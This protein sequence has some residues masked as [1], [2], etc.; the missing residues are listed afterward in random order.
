MVGYIE[1]TYPTIIL[2]VYVITLLAYYLKL[3]LQ[4][5][6]K[7]NSRGLLLISTR[8]SRWDNLTGLEQNMKFV[9]DP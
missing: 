8:T 6:V 1:L 9:V 4:I 3:H 2:I 5:F 7:K